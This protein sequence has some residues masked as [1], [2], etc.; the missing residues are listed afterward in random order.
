MAVLV[1]EVFLKPKIFYFLFFF[2]GE[3]GLITGTPPG[4]QP[5]W[6]CTPRVVRCVPVDSP[7]SDFG[8][9]QVLRTVVVLCVRSTV[10]HLARL[11]ALQ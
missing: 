5:R 4:V 8:V 9:K 1:T 3:S 11:S 10:T 6:G 7:F 2:D